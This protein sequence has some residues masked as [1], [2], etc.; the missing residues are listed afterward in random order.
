[1]S[2]PADGIYGL[3]EIYDAQYRAYREDLV[4]YRRL[5]EDRAGTVLEIGCGTGRVTFE[6]AR[7]GAHVVGVDDAPEMLA[8]A[9][10]RLEDA[11]VLGSVRLIE[12]DMRRLQEAGAVPAG[13]FEVA[14]A[15]FNTLMHAYTLE[16]QD[17]TLQAVFAALAPG[18]TFACDVYVPRFGPQHVV[19]VEP[20]WDRVMGPEADLF[21]IQEHDAAR[22]HIVSTYLIDRIEASGH[23]RRQRARLVQRYYTPFEIERAVGAAGF[24]DVRIYGSFERAPF[25]E[26]SNVIVVVARKPGS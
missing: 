10:R 14:V 5:A 22:Q 12:A 3:P 23:V 8:R 15:P 26:D 9:R 13:T 6:L 19:R 17:R 4:F 25:R 21:L 1:M 7:A 16:D 11:G 20:T 24:E 18:G 2:A